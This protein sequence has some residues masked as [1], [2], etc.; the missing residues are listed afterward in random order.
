MDA[1]QQIREKG[2]KVTPARKEVINVLTGSH[3]AYAHAELEQLFDKMDRVTLYRVLKDFEDVGLVHKI[4]DV[5]GVTRFAAC[6]HSCPDSHHA[7]EHVHFNC[8]TC[9]KVFCLEKVHLPELKMPVGFKAIGLQ[10]LIYGLCKNCSV[11]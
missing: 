3:M 6:K 9:H 1:L 4:M 7:D 8:N 10:T 5:D 2:L 11:A